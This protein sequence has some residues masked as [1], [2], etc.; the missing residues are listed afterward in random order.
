MIALFLTIRLHRYR[1]SQDIKVTDRAPCLSGKPELD[2]EETRSC[3]QRGPG[4]LHNPIDAPYEVECDMYCTREIYNE[5]D[6]WAVAAEMIV[7]DSVGREDH[8]GSYSKTWH[9]DF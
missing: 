5:Q 8:T 9:G 3:V 1:H 2:A 6:L 4:E 7:V